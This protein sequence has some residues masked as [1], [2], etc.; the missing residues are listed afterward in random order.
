[1]ETTDKRRVWTPSWKGVIITVLLGVNI[2]LI[3]IIEAL[4]YRWRNY[5][6]CEPHL[7]KF[8]HSAIKELCVTRTNM[9]TDCHLC[10]PHWLLHGDHCYY[11]SEVTE[12]TWSQS[13]DDCKMMGAD[14]LVIKDQEQQNFIQIT[15]KKQEDDTYWIGLYHDGDVWRWVDGE[16][17]SGSL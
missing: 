14:L 16:H 17:Y 1:M 9:S 5:E 15:L 8:D 4:V 12:R 2:I 13:R 10:P 11:Y 3:R 6:T 7:K